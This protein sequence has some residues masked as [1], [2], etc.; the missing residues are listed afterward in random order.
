MSRNRGRGAIVGPVDKSLLEILCC[1]V[2]RQPLRL[3]DM[4]TLRRASTKTAA[5]L[6]EGLLREDGQV[7]YPVKN[8]IPLLIPEEGLSLD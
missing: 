5:P 2:T 1:P 6:A 8:G 3:A 4:D 7:L